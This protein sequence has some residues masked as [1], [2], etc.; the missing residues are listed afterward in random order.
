[1]ETSLAEKKK[2]GPE[3]TLYDHLP[4]ERLELINECGGASFSTG[5][6]N[7]WVF[8]NMVFEFKDMTNISKT[9]RNGLDLR[10]RVTTGHIETMLTSEDGTRKGLVRFPDGTGAECVS[11]PS[12]RG[13]TFCISTMAGCP[14][15][16]LFCA[17]G[18]H[19][20]I[21]NFTRGE[22]LSQYLLL[23]RAVETY[24]ANAVL[25]GSGEPLLN[26]SETLGFLYMLNDP[27]LAGLGARR[28]TV[29]TV[30]IP[31]AIIRL[32]QEEVQ[33]EIA[34]SLHH[35]DEK[36]RN[37]LIPLSR[38]NPTAAVIEALI[39]Y[40]RKTNRLPTV[41]YCLLA[42]I[43][44]SPGCARKT[45]RLVRRVRAKVNLIPYNRYSGPFR[46]P[47]PECVDAFRTILENEGITVTVRRQMG[48]DINAA[49]GQLAGNIHAGR[50][51]R[52]RGRG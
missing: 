7:N 5:Q 44:D 30:G 4:S 47:D 37:R 6:I 35:P 8:R 26:F 39:V 38:K 15:K 14:G 45:A 48:A 1:M 52:D 28:I 27:D 19:G 46:A 9:V 2:T 17:S 43:N 23:S 42:G 3:T 21:R 33:F 18:S 29:S 31:D 49:C 16:C 13:V 50:G 11:I 40:T 24:P 10:T 12:G 34:F 32:A 20:R 51:T 22:M 36:E 25:M 41:E